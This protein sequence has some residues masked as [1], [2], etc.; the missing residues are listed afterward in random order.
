MG[1]GARQ[2]S[3]RVVMITGA[4]GGLGA[5]YGRAFAAAGATVA[6]FDLDGEAAAAR[7]AEI[8]AA[9]GRAWADRCDVTEEAQCRAAVAAV[10]DREG[11]LDVLVNNAGITH[12]SAFTD[13]AS[14]VYRR[15]MAVNFFGALYCTQAALPALRARG[16]TIVAISSI[17]G[18]AP[19]F[20]RSG[21][22]A[23]KHAVHGLFESL[24]CELA[25]TGVGVLIVCPG[26]TATG[27][28]AAA[29]DGDGRR[30][31]HPQSTV[32]RVADPDDVARA[33]VEA[34]RRRRRLLVL[35]AAGR[36]SWWVSR[37]APSLYERLMTR[38]LRRELER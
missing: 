28:G 3:G 13:T 5:A 25:G 12:R 18:F 22:S 31:A 2:I 23:S 37:L 32:G 9:G 7:A 16:G 11:G 27:I 33:V 4:G 19:L 17:A 26:F 29:L 15:V 35:T 1:H 10:L 8:R 6:L 38:G 36:A 34:V 30:T 20:G 14:E 24:R 21:Y